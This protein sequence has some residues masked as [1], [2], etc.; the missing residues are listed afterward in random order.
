[1][2][3]NR[4]KDVVTTFLSCS[5]RPRDWPLVDALAQKVL[6]PQGFRCFT[7]GRNVSLPEQ[8]DDAI[9]RLMAS[10]ECLI[11]VATE[12][13]TAT[14][15]DFPAKTLTVATPYLLQET[16]M[17]F[18]ADLPFLMFKT[19]EVSLL[20]VTNRNLWIEIASDLNPKGQVKFHVTQDLLLTSLRDL[21]K[22][23]LERRAR[24]TADQW[25]TAIGALSTLVL[26]GIGLSKG[27]DILQR[28]DCF[29]EFY[30]RDAEC[31]QCDYRDRCKVEKMERSA[32]R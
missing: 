11:G 9:R 2:E 5:V 8:S 19:R 26:G 22:K 1:M 18:Q 25:K 27:I 29:G 20:G 16:S 32:D 10:C 17:A 15:R 3:I 23:A 12:R 21:K 4:S 31:K 28:P 13:L 6:A 24:M 30:Y 14:D 7:V